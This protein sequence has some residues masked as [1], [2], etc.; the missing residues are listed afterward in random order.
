MT[1]RPP[2]EDQPGIPVQRSTAHISDEALEES[3][4]YWR[5]IVAAMDPMTKEEI[6]DV[7]AVLRRIDARRRE[8]NG[9]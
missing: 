8:T 9:D 6:A 1:G 4:A 2:N 3:L 7:A 5:P